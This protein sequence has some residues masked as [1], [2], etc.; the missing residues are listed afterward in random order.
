MGPQKTGSDGATL[1]ELERGVWCSRKRSSVYRTFS[2][3]LY[4][5]DN[6]AWSSFDGDNVRA[7]SPSPG[8]G[9]RCPLVSDAHNLEPRSNPAPHNRSHRPARQVRPSAS[10]VGFSQIRASVKRYPRAIL[11]TPGTSG[12]RLPYKCVLRA[13]PTNPSDRASEVMTCLP[14]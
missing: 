5:V 14:P 11:S 7:H 8:G 10:L 9:K 6:V 1:T 4:D 3:I 12:H 2:T 13:L